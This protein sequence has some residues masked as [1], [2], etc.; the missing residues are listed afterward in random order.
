MSPT[1]L[2]S[3]HDGRKAL[4]VD[5]PALRKI[6]DGLSSRPL[7]NDF[8]ASELA[9]I[10]EALPELKFPVTSAGHLLDQLAGHRLVV[11]RIELDPARMAKYVPAHYFPIWSYDNLIE[12]MAELVRAN[13]PV[14]DTEAEVK[15]LRRQ[16]P[17]LKYPIKSAND[18]IQ[19]LGTTRTY[20]FLGGA[21]DVKQAVSHIPD[22]LFP[23]D[24]DKDLDL[25]LAYLI[26][27]RPLIVGHR[28][29]GGTGTP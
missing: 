26:N 18:L 29:G 8:D 15:A 25:K 5:S 13:R 24:S 4:S 14:V 1:N 19:A 27:R 10:F 28:Q 2:T 11:H 6:I 17:A 7:V 20:R 12:K 23:I 9:A 21:V 3:R 22:K 16:I